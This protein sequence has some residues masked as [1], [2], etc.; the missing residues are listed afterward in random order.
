MGAAIA[1]RLGRAEHSQQ[2]D[3]RVETLGLKKTQLIG[4]QSRE[5]RVTDEIDC[6]NA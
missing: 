4:S 1:Q 3:A 2:L 5:T 6:G